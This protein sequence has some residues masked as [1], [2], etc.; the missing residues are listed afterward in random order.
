MPNIFKCDECGEIV[1]SKKTPI[2][3]LEVKRMAGTD[4]NYE[5]ISAINVKSC[6]RVCPV[7]YKKFLPQWPYP[8]KDYAEN[9]DE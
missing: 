5:E 6:R 1:D 8:Y 4:E 3:H 7:C 2:I 9:D